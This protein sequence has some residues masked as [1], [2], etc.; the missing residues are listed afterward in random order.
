MSETPAKAWI[1]CGPYLQ[2]AILRSDGPPIEEVQARI[3]SGR[4][5]FWP[6]DQAAA[7]Y[8]IT[9]DANCW[10]A[11]G[12]YEEIIRRHPEAEAW[13]RQMGCERM[14]LRGRPGWTRALAPLG[15]APLTYLVKEL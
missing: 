15:Y 13:A 7:V 5:F 11:G 9:K 6:G 10:L 3:E 2:G 1:R 12:S 4:A 14:T 8:E